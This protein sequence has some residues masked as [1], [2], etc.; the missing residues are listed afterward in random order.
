VPDEM[1]L[2]YTRNLAN[3]SEK[4]LDY[5]LKCDLLEPLTISDMIKSNNIGENEDQENVTIASLGGVLLGFSKLSVADHLFPKYRENI[6]MRINRE[7][8]NRTPF[9]EPFEYESAYPKPVTAQSVEV[10]LLASI[11]EDIDRGYI[12]GVTT[13][14]YEPGDIF[15]YN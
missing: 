2:Y 14:D 8:F 10:D 4:L 13:S 15:I 3:E 11:Q 5:A 6:N 1:L 9:L 12:M 7:V